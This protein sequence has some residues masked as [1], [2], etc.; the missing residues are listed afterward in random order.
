MKAYAIRWNSPE[1]VISWCESHRRF[2][3]CTHKF[4]IAD[5]QKS[6]T[7]V[8]RLLSNENPWITEINGWQGIAVPYF[9]LIMCC[10]YTSTGV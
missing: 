6:N 10:V 9:I 8:G 4:K 2:S 1:N 7:A 3:L 5:T